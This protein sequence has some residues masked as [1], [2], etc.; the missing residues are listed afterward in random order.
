[1]TFVEAI[2]S[3]FKNYVKFDGRASRS[4]FWW[5]FLFYVIVAVVAGIVGSFAGQNAGLGLRALVGL[6]FFLPMLGL[7]I[8]RLHDTGRSGWW[9]FISLIPIV[10]II[11]LIVWLASKGTDGPNKYGLG[12]G[13]TH[14]ASKFE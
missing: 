5:F 11:L 10:G 8:R 6:V 9:I 12:A 3:G 7:E 2:Q 13:V 1:M 14:L 4:E